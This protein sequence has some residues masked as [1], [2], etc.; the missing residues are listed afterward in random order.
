MHSEFEMYTENPRGDVRKTVGGRR[1][2]QRYK[3]GNYPIK[4]VAYHDKG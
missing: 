2:G 4:I 3:F 1:S